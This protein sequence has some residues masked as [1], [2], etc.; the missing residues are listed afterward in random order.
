M[1]RGRRPFCLLQQEFTHFSPGIAADAFLLAAV[2]QG[3][4]WGEGA[5]TCA[6]FAEIGD[7]V[8]WLNPA[9]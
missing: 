4:A 5:Q 3:R 8:K 6:Y 2:G 1:G 7:S 9:N